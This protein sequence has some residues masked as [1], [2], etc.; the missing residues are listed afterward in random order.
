MGSSATGLKAR[1][2]AAVQLEESGV[3]HARQGLP[4]VQRVL[5]RFGDRA[6]GQ[7]VR[8]LRFQRVMK[9]VDDRLQSL[10]SHLVPHGDE[11]FI[12]YVLSPADFGLDIIAQG[13]G[14]RRP[15]SVIKV[16]HSSPPASST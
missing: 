15:A 12:V 14:F 16:R 9:R 3:Q 2:R 5:D 10:L 1:S 11:R 13:T 6:L 4:M 7:D 8:Q